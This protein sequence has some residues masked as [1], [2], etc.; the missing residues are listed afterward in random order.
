MVIRLVKILFF[1]LCCYSCSSKVLMFDLGDVLFEQSHFGVARSV[2]LLK[3]FS[4]SLLDHQSPD[5][6]PLLFD[7]LDT[8]SP[9][10]DSDPDQM[11][12][13]PNGEPLPQVMCDWLTGTIAPRDF[14]S[15]AHKKIDM[16]PDFVSY[17]E[18]DLVRSVVTSMADPYILINNTRPIK[19]GVQLLRDCA[20]YRD[21]NGN[22]HT[23]IVLSNW[24]PYS[25]ELLYDRYLNLFNLFD[26][27][28]ISG[29]IGLAKPHHACF[30][31]V[32]D[33]LHLNP[34][35]CYLIDDQEGNI[36][37]AEQCA[38]HG[39]R[40]NHKNYRALRKQLKHEGLF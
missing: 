15:K 24:D 19:A 36:K 38:M 17:R 12:C 21:E 2:G 28:I 7:V 11:I 40:L 1:L 16:F 35:D 32:L 22:R 39:L 33:T 20:A 5:I 8:C 37:A 27:I 4:Y 30:K 9:Q 29:H 34:D 10:R 3:F 25:F 18:E 6:Q 31:H 26:H 23:L 13:A 14:I